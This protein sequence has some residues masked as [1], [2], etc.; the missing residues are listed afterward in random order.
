M[1]RFFVT[2]GAIEGET[3]T[4]AGPDAH[5]MAHVLRMKTGEDF[6]G[7]DEEGRVYTCRIEEFQRSGAD[8]VSARRGSRARRRGRN[9]SRYKSVKAV[10]MRMFARNISAPRT[11]SA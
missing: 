9:T 3:L 10:K 2:S 5:H 4:I 6:E 11:D 1:Y 7:V 8:E